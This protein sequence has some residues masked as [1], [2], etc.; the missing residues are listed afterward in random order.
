[1]GFLPEE[2]ED[3]FWFLVANIKQNVQWN[4]WG[5]MFDIRPFGAL[6][7]EDFVGLSCTRGAL[8]EGGKRGHPAVRTMCVAAAWQILA[9]VPQVVTCGSKRPGNSGLRTTIR[10][11]PGVRSGHA[12]DADGTRESLGY[13]VGGPPWAQRT[14]STTSTPALNVTLWLYILLQ[15]TSSR[16]RHM[17]LVFAERLTRAVG[18]ISGQHHLSSAPRRSFWGRV[19]RRGEG[20]HGHDTG[21]ARGVQSEWPAAKKSW[22]VV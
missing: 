3:T 11:T 7:D 12:N 18:P 8:A 10:T 9:S 19:E 5:T 22:H 17:S 21:V 4:V 2:H 6:R 14:N 1:M 16:L 15:N 13:D 20:W